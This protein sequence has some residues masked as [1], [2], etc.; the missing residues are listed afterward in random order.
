M[1]AAAA[2]LVVV[3]AAA[4]LPVAVE[5]AP[6]ATFEDPDWLEAALVTELEANLTPMLIL[7]PDTTLLPEDTGEP[8]TVFNQQV[9]L[10]IPFLPPT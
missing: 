7:D 3:A 9:P 6:V 5:K 4:L 8:M 10:P 1:V 2:P